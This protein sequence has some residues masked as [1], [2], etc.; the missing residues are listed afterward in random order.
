MY[1]LASC[2]N[3]VRLS[4]RSMAR[5]AWLGGWRSQGR[6]GWGWVDVK[7]E[8]KNDD[9][10]QCRSP[11]A[12]RR[13]QFGCCAFTTS[14]EKSHGNAYILVPPNLVCVCVYC[15][16]SVSCRSVPSTM[17]ACMHII[18]ILAIAR[19]PS[20]SIYY[21]YFYLRCFCYTARKVYRKKNS[22]RIADKSLR[23]GERVERVL[24]WGGGGR[25]NF[26][27]RRNEVKG[28]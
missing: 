12:G 19:N 27:K 18:I 15:L 6:V 25:G 4:S 2:I 11:A 24:R 20:K 7:N 17:H 5:S 13:H 26:L 1:K 8:K 9:I 21:Q 22:G 23:L 3:P 28:Q 14:S 10:T 16:G